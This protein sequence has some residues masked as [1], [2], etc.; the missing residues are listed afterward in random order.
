MY[1]ILKMEY[2]KEIEQKEYI[3]GEESTFDNEGE[4]TN[5]IPQYNWLTNVWYRFVIHS[6]VD[7]DTKKTYV[8]EWIQNLDTEEWTLL[9]YFDVGLKILF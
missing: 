8:G 4:G 6:W 2:E 3:P 1:F 5:F 7:Q 9:T